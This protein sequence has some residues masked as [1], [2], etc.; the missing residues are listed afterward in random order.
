M[1]A[2]GGWTAAKCRSWSHLTCHWRS[3][4][5]R[6][7]LRG[8]TREDPRATGVAA[9]PVGF[10]THDDDGREEPDFAGQAFDARCLPRSREGQGREGHTCPCCLRKFVRSQ[11]G[12]RQSRA[13]ARMTL[14][15]GYLIS[16]LLTRQRAVVDRRTDGRTDRT[17]PCPV[18]VKVGEPGRDAWKRTGLRRRSDKLLVRRWSVVMLQLAGQMAG[19][20]PRHGPCLTLD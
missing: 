6:S 11:L 1:W 13:V 3:A 2:P 20:R 10:R 4:A 12:T 18:A 17:G 5:G 8:A 9:E 16:I 7:K 15:L 14:W 19:V